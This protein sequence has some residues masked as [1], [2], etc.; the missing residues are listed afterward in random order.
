MVGG[1]ERFDTEPMFL[2]SMMRVCL[3][4]PISILFRRGR[5]S[6]GKQKGRVRSWL[7]SHGRAKA[8]DRTP[9]DATPSIAAF[10]RRRDAQFDRGAPHQEFTVSSVERRTIDYP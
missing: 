5:R 7:S 3:I 8:A 4:H 1:V 9:M 2:P 6:L 10:D